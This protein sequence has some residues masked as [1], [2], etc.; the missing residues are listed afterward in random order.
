MVSTAVVAVLMLTTSLPLGLLVLIGLPVI[1]ASTT[2][3]IRPLQAKQ[4]HMREEQGKLTTIAADAVAGLRVLRG[5]G[6][7]DRFDDAY[8]RQSAQVRDAGISMSGNAAGLAVI[9]EGVP[10]AFMLVVVAS[11]AVLTLRGDLSVGN[12]V[13]FYGFTAYLQAPISTASNLIEQY[14]RAWVGLSKMARILAVE[15]PD[16]SIPGD[17]D[18]PSP[19]PVHAP[20]TSAEESPSSGDMNE[21]DWWA[22][23]TL[24]DPDSGV[25]IDAGRITAVVAA[26]PDE[27]AS[28][29]RRLAGF[30]PGQAM[31]EDRK[32]ATL[33]RD[34]IRR[35]IYFLGADAQVFSGSLRDDLLGAGAPM[36]RPHGTTELVV[37]D[38][39][40]AQSLV[41]LPPPH[42][43]DPRDPALYAAIDVADAH[44][45]LTSL[46]GGLD[47]VLLE[48]GRNLSGGQRQRVALARAVAAKA[49]VLVLVEPTS[50][51]DAHTEARIA[52]KLAVQRAGQ[53]T[54]IVTASPLVLEECDVIEVV[55]E[56][57]TRI[58]EGTHR[59][60]RHQAEAG[61]PGADAYMRI[62][63]RRMGQA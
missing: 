8:R 25:R 10:L 23:A 17:E 55:D 53:T 34:E 40:A 19:S 63:D 59:D 33:A 57:G 21:D 13:A 1:I 6:G 51:L 48:K 46:P 39:I 41:E 62:I 2:L 9:K 44:D 58:A 49:P 50:A 12:L 43:D 45:V 16:E 22:H 54:V 11:G 4:T 52:R 15:D 37:R 29:A 31:V 3:L 35:G 47:G 18:E 26:D 7:E 42:I 5:I 27:G 36:R 60:L 56:Q 20:S 61:D 30:D 14:T 28:I 32:L 24:R 38:E